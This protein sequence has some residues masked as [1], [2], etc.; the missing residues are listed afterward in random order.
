M[1]EPVTETADA[2]LIDADDPLL[3]DEVAARIDD[4]R[5]PDRLAWNATRTLALW[6][7]D[8]WVPP[9]LSMALGDGN[10]LSPLEWGGTKVFPWRIGIEA[11]ET[12]EA[13]LDGPEGYVVVVFTFSTD[14][15]ETDLRAAEIGALDGSIHGGR[16]AGV[17][18]VA[19]PGADGDA[20]T[21][22]LERAGEVELHDG[23]LAWDLLAD[24]TGIVDWAYL[25]RLALDL[26]EEGDPDDTL[27][28]Q[29]HR[30]VSDLQARFPD[31]VI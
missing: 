15:S 4:P 28:E 18:L 7:A 26:V 30:L 27:T 29:V 3:T 5:R 20:L 10:P 14:P 19:P 23:R 1:D 22:I 6:D 13:V 24:S 8:T 16:A 12:C 11:V 9:L 21:G 25:G 2:W 31:A 17:V